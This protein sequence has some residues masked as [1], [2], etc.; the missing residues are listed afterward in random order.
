MKKIIA[1]FCFFCATMIIVCC[2]IN[3][4][5]DIL[6][7]D[8]FVKIDIDTLSYIN[9][10]IG[11][12]DIYAFIKMLRYSNTK[13]IEKTDITPIK[14]EEGITLAYLVE[15]ND[16][17]CLIA[18]DRRLSPIIA[19]NKEDSFSGMDSGMK[20]LL[21]HELEIIEA[22]KKGIMSVPEQSADFLNSVSF[23]NRISKDKTPYTKADGDP[24]E[25]NKYWELID[26]EEIDSFEETSGHLI[27]TRWHQFHPWNLF[28]PS[29]DATTNSDLHDA[30]GC[31]AIATAQML[32][33][34]NDKIGKPETAP[35]N[36]YCS[37]YSTNLSDTTHFQQYFYNFSS[38]AW[39][40][41]ALNDTDFFKS[42][43]LSALLIGYT[44]KS[45]HTQYS[46]FLSLAP[47]ENVPSFLSSQGI[48]SSLNP[49]SGS[50]VF[51]SI[52]TNEMPVIISAHGKK[53]TSFF[54][55]VT[56][57]SDG[58]AFIADD[59]LL[60][61]RIYLCT[62]QWTSH[63]GGDHYYGEIKTERDTIPEY[64][65]R[66]NWGFS[67]QTPNNTYYSTSSH[68]FQMSINDTTYNFQYLLNQITGFSASDN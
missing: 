8:G 45:I 51:G 31:T 60:V 24:E 26:M 52:R 48:Q 61:N 37:G 15:F 67:N 29:W 16:G 43:T 46:P 33:Y 44:G 34:L 38:T 23:W 18:A 39:D 53:E 11:L 22:L 10:D 68:N 3:N 9:Y 66:M 36:G 58:H 63:I 32:Y 56:H 54:G 62:Y 13:T 35:T 7:E 2:S 4:N 41:M 17:W 55:L 28:A 65:I 59:Y 49:Y 50:W 30:A 20:L 19:F 6:S 47:I 25:E 12:D 40:N 42:D 57:Y 64:Y 5:E 21:S 27:Q 14:S 1:L